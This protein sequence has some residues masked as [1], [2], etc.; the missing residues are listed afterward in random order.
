MH[1]VITCA[2]PMVL[3]AAAFV[4]TSPALV[5]PRKRRWSGIGQPLRPSTFPFRSDPWVSCSAESGGTLGRLWGS[6]KDKSGDAGCP[7]VAALIRRLRTSTA[8]IY[9]VEGSSSS[10]EGLHE[11]D[12]CFLGSGFAYD[13]GSFVVTCAH[14]FG[15]RMP[16]ARLAVRFGDGCWYLAELWGSDKTSDV[17][18]V[19]LTETRDGPVRQKALALSSSQ[20]L[21][22]QGEWVVVSGTTQHCREAV[23]VA[24]LVSQPRQAFRGL[25]EDPAMHFVQLALP[26][27]PGMSGSPAVNLRGE[28]VALVAKK[29]EEHGLALP[30]GRVASVARCLESGRLWKPPVLGLELEP[31]GC[32]TEPRVKV[33][34]VHR[35][36]PAD[37]AGIKAEDEIHYVEGVAITSI[38][39]VREAIGALGDATGDVSNIFA[40]VRLQ[41]KRDG[42]MLHTVVKT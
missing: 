33:R 21:P 39:D 31:G 36:G 6:S 34:C 25:A 35:G 17:A 30:A 20:P 15:D 29:F 7:D 18:V 12:T 38:L 10:L 23:A 13:N 37:A 5:P 22:E 4:T 32:L 14:L 27:L 3:A 24:G 42:R 41:L 16:G 1:R 9:S 19:R 8:S 2:D 11:A 28:V 26:T 40:G